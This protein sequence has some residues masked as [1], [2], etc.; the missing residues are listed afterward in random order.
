MYKLAKLVK[1]KPKKLLSITSKYVTLLTLAILSSWISLLISIFL[2][3]ILGN[4]HPLLI[5]GRILVNIDCVTNIIC[6][7][8]QYP[9]NRDYYDKFCVCFAKCCSYLLNKRGMNNKM[10]DNNGNA[11]ELGNKSPTD[12]R[13][14]STLPDTDIVN[15]TDETTPESNGNEK[16]L[17]ENTGLMIKP[18][19]DVVADKS[20]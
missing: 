1:E 19:G 5:I 14:A 7:Y 16:I 13:E 18:N 20:F 4:G 10:E 9:F 15:Q 2:I 17:A 6:L 12:E 8:L 11:I 3:M